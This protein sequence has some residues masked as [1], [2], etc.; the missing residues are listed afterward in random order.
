MSEATAIALLL[1]TL[2]ALEH[3]ARR[4]HPARFEALL[5]SLGDRDAALRQVLAGAHGPSRWAMR[6][7]VPRK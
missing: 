2:E 7:A 6:S 4:L 1:D 5:A 3:I